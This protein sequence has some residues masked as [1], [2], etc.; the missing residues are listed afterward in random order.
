MDSISVRPTWIP[1]VSRAF[2]EDQIDFNLRLMTGMERMTDGTPFF[3][4][5]VMKMSVAHEKNRVSL[6][7]L[8]N[9]SVVS[10]LCR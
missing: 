7:N 1:F 10:R 4:D 5:E 9:V 3:S 8:L 6:L 2:A